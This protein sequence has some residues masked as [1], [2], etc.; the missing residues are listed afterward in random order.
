MA[1]ATRLPQ[2]I[3]IQGSL[4]IARPIGTIVRNTADGALYASTN[5]VVPTYIAVASA[6]TP[7]IG[8]V[9]TVATVGGDHTTIAAAI[10]AAVA[11][12]VILVYPGTYAE[13]N[14]LTLPAGVSLNCVGR[15]EVTSMT[16]NNAGSHGLVAG[17][18]NEI[19]GLQIT[20]ASG[21][22]SA[23]FHVPAG[24]EN[25]EWHDCKIQDCDIG[26][27]SQTNTVSPNIH[28]YM[29]NV[30]RGTTTSVFKTDSGGLMNVVGAFVSDPVVATQVFHVD[31]AGSTIRV[32]SSRVNGGNTTDAALAENGGLAV[33][34]ACHLRSVATGL[35]VAA[36]GGTLRGIACTIEDATTAVRCGAGGN[37]ECDAI[38]I[39]GSTVDLQTDA[40]TSEITWSGGQVDT[41]KISQF[42]GSTIIANYL[43]AFAGDRGTT[44]LGELHVGAP[45]MGAETVL[46]EGDSSV[47]DMFVFTDDGTGTAFIDESA[48]AKDGTAYSPFQ[49]GAVGDVVYFGNSS[50]EFPGLKINTTTALVHA[51][52]SELIWE[53]SDGAGG[54]NA[55][56]IMVTDADNPYTQYA[57][58]A[59]ERAPEFAQIRFDPDTVVWG[60]NTVNGQAA[61]WFRCR[62]ATAGLG[63]AP[64]V[65]S[66]DLTP[67]TQA[68]TKLHTN[69]YEINA[70]GLTERFGESIFPLLIPLGPRF[71]ASGGAS[72]GNAVF[73]P[74]ANVGWTDNDGSFATAGDA[75][76]WQVAVPPGLDT[77]RPIT[78][79]VYW[80]PSTT[81]VAPVTMRLIAVEIMEGDSVTG[82]ALIEVTD[83]QVYTGSGT[84][85]NAEA[86][87]SHTVTLPN[88]RPGQTIVLQFER[89]TATGGGTPA[90]NVINVSASGFYWLG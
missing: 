66:S 21:A 51:G 80:A 81:G 45:G 16:C 40:A 79:D 70:D 86:V 54:W 55:V 25:V 62:V 85:G 72:P 48:D 18:E 23:A 26:W 61:R 87:V 84:A 73:A 42:A 10:A 90:I 33:V 37:I 34:T 47:I 78:F 67:T 63:T 14:P 35:R 53:V 41:T 58:A 4:L 27:L 88:V 29:P 13:N 32:V 68:S 39:S 22:G 19:I 30:E 24:V 2:G 50:R 44:V 17:G 49:T 83:D 56:A 11:G 65:S 64:V 15:H 43:E 57:Q 9:I 69:R 59:F 31:G 28:C 38:R 71:A 6:S 76:I 12:D 52:G 20:G 89:I 77:S 60:D 74:S 5:A 1:D 8:N 36:T 46:G 82:G 3:V 75:V 7:I